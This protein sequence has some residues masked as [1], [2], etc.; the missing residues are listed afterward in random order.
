MSTT[1]Y[2]TTPANDGSQDDLS[3]TKTSQGNSSSVHIEP[4]HPFTSA[5]ADVLEFLAR[6]RAERLA[7][8]KQEPS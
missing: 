3:L 1:N 8:N 5:L 2:Q 6:K 4:K 7:N